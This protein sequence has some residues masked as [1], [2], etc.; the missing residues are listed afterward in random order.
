MK[1]TNLLGILM[2]SVLIGI[3][4]LLMI[5]PP[6]NMGGHRGISQK[7]DASTSDGNTFVERKVKVYAPTRFWNR[8]QDSL[9]TSGLSFA[10]NELNESELNLYD[11]LLSGGILYE[12]LAA[13]TGERLQKILEGEFAAIGLTENE[14]VAPGDA[15]TYSG[16]P[17]EDGAFEN[18]E[19]NW[20]SPD[21][22]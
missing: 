17:V 16:Q 20:L 13:D 8:Q 10:E 11:G 21:R 5:T 22:V 2:I 6:L 18:S 12:V 3:S 15:V 9:D 1:Q 14:D 7:E 19:E 4:L